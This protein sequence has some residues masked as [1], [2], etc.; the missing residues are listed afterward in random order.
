MPTA[1][2]A[3]KG[4]TRARRA[5]A[6]ARRL[7]ADLK[8]EGCPEVWMDS[9]RRPNVAHLPEPLMKH[10]GE[11]DGGIARLQGTRLL[12]TLR[13]ASITV[14][15]ISMPL[16]TAFK[17]RAGD[18]RPEIRLSAAGAGQH[19]GAHHQLT[20]RSSSSPSSR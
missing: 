11:G 20:T 12:V 18:R 13:A 17:V 2:R 3:A 8:A 9:N 16:V 6:R 5:E 19:V 10:P 14:R 1:K 15:T 4:S 7:V